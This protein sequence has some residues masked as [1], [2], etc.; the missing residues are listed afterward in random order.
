[1]NPV[2]LLGW[3]ADRDAWLNARRTG[4][5]ASDVAALLGFTPRWCTPW[6]LWAEKHG[7]LPPWGGNENTALGQALEPWLIAQA[8]TLLDQPVER[9]PHMLYAH[10]EHDWRLCSP[11]AFAEDGALVEA[12][13]AKIGPSWGD[14]EGWEDDGVPLGYEF[15]ARWAMHVMNRH[16]VYMIGLIAGMGLVVRTINRDMG[17]EQDMVAQ[18]SQWRQNH[19]VAGAEPPV[20]GND[21]AALA[22]TYAIASGEK[23]SL[24][25]TE[26]LAWREEY[27]DILTAEAALK[28]RK[29]E[30]KALF[31]AQLKTGNIGVIG[32][33][34]IC[35]WNPSKGDVDWQRMSHDLA[36]LADMPMPDPETY[37]KP[38]GRT[39][40]VK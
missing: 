10:P 1:M 40:L 37:R 29:N 25:H 11:D 4:I 32:D 26:A 22:K 20:D 3:D 34:T 35:T 39:L 18:V 28:K 7:K 5:G 12:K 2:P 38:P 13:T 21:I 14:P 6:Q 27:K 17:I 33:T 16:R 30:L 15:Q 23:V 9:T 8:P 19:I 36:K 31:Q 24:S